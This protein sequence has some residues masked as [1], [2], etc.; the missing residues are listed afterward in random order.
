MI[1]D[2]GIDAYASLG[3]DVNKQRRDGTQETTE[4]IVSQKQKELDLSDKDEDL[5]KIIEKGEKKWKESPKK[6]EWEKMGD[7]NE[8]YWLGQH[9]ET[10]KADKSRPIVDNAIFEGLET[11][12]PQATRRNPEPLISLDAGE[13]GPDGNSDPI[14]LAYVQKV[15]LRLSDLADKNALRLKLKK[16]ARH[17]AIFLLGVAKFGWDLDRDIPIVRIVRPKKIILD[18]DATIDEDGY[19]GDYIGEYRKMT[20]QKILDI[21]GDDEGKN[22]AKKVIKEMVKDDLGTEIQFIEWWTPQYVCW[23]LNKEILFKKKNPNWNYEAEPSTDKAVDDYGNET[24]TQAEPKPA[25]NHFSSPQ[26]PYAFLSVFNLGDQPMDK[27]SLIGQNLSNQDGI[28]KRNKQVDKNVDKMNGGAVV[29]LE[30]SGLTST[31]AKGVSEAVRKGGT[32]LIPQGA[33][34][35]A[36]YFPTVPSLPADVFNDLYDKRSRL[37]DI[38]GTA[39]SSQ[40]GLADEQTVRGKI[41]SRGLDTDRI[42][43]GV[44]EYLE[45]FAGQIYNYLL[46]MLYV[47]DA[48]FQFLADGTPPKVLVS[49]KEGSLLPKDS[50][51]IAN[52]ALEIAK[53]NRISNIDLY[54]RLEYPNPEEMAANVWLETN[55]PQIL[56][57]DNPLVQEAMGMMQA[58]QQAAAQQEAT[59]GV[60][61]HGQDMEKQDAKHA[62][63]MEGMAAKTILSQVPTGGAAP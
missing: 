58:Q 28:N 52:Q 35:D 59:A 19:T 44:T 42:G 6:V 23:K 10:P 20:A 38:F 8:K 24:E 34:Q 15:K 4:G 43:G 1:A 30:K 55:A 46:Q 61:A 14:K 36:V 11:Y 27:T 18:P 21:I 9:Y 50:T 57:K 25:I 12:L 60:V 5:V 41:L 62:A 22:D 54:K 49:V 45:Q 26:M 16:G 31:Q 40:A 39:G 13:V 37:R 7:E 29:S 53:L 51:S 32:I 47:Y 17:W 63:D 33:A 48:S 2:T 56:Y 3:A